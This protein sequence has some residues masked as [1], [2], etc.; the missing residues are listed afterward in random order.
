MTIQ[1]NTW[2]LF[3]IFVLVFVFI[4][5]S[6]TIYHEKA[7]QEI[8]QIFG[9]KDSY[10]EYG[11]MYLNGKTHDGFCN[12]TIDQETTRLKMHAQNEVYGYHLLFVIISILFSGFLISLTIFLN[13]R[14]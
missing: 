9:C 4:L 1:E 7:H 5:M 14:Y 13:K 11:F 12:L 3:I 10:I 2:F 8:N 6:Y